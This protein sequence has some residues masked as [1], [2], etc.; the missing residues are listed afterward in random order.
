ML[1]Y[2]LGRSNWWAVFILVTVLLIGTPIYT[3]VF[4]LFKGGGDSWSH[5]LDNLLYD[6]IL[7]SFLIV[8]I[9]SSITLFFGISS[10]W[11]VTTHHFPLR[12]F[13]EWGLILPLAIPTYIAAFSYAGLFDYSGLLSRF[14][15]TFGFGQIEIM[16][17]WGVSFVMSFVLYPYVYLVSRAAFLHQSRSLIE[18]ARGLGSNSVRT[19]FTVAIPVARPAIIGG[20]TLVLMEVLNDY[21]AVKYYG[22]STFTTG[23]FRAWFSLNDTASAIKL[24]ALLL[25]FVLVLILFERFQRGSAR[26]ADNKRVQRP[27]PRFK[28]EWYVQASVLLFCSIPFLL[29][30]VLPIVQLTDWS[31]LTASKILKMDFILLIV[32]SFSLALLASLICVMFSVFLIYG[33]RINYSVVLHSL[34]RIATLGYS[35]PGAV[36]AIGVM[37]PFIALDRQIKQIMLNLAG[38]DIGLLLSGSIF[39]L[40]FAYLVRF[41]AVSYNPIEA[42]FNKTSIHLEEAARSLGAGS[43]KTLWKIDMPIIKTSALSALLLVFVDVL[44]ELPLTLILRPFNFH[45]LATKTYELASDEMIAESANPALVI[46]LT[47]IIPILVIN[48]LLSKKL[49]DGN[50][51]H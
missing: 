2:I 51:E 24:S 17:I 22:V 36:V 8:L 46:I 6:Y 25:S 23:I 30:F 47:G 21:G 19:F 35:I 50:I 9:V 10:A 7:N 38:I 13:L 5:I 33:V 37:M 48:R 39:A 12:R 32:N 3:I 29:G 44:K 42:G 1:R 11:F 4:Q 16:N 41:I 43:F 20:L 45:T 27:M 49:P 26:F 15:L 14:F 34:A 28:S 40:V 18:A 31:F